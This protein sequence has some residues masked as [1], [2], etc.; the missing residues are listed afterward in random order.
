[1]P[2]SWSAFPVSGLTS[3]P[4]RGRVKFR[5]GAGLVGA[6]EKIGTAGGAWGTGTGAGSGA[7]SAASAF[8]AAS[9][10]RRPLLAR[11]STTS[12][13]ASAGH[14]ATIRP[15]HVGWADIT[16]APMLAAIPTAKPTFVFHDG[17]RP[18]ARASTMAT[19]ATMS[20]PSTLSG[21]RCAISSRS[22]ASFATSAWCQ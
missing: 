21:R 5:I 8:A 13:R 16:F 14:A 7:G 19:D 4:S 2:F 10:M 1:L 11:I 6:A 22:P 18:S 3:W 15:S 12:R 17:L 20:R 9:R